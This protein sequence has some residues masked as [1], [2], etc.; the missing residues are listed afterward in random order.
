MARTPTSRV[1]S[2]ALSVAPC[3]CCYFYLQALGRWR[4]LPIPILGGHIFQLGLCGDH[5]AWRRRL[6]IELMAMAMIR[7]V[8]IQIRQRL[9][10]TRWG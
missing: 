2:K 10:G 7:S 8:M 1:S 9:N 3:S 5:R 4:A 6:V